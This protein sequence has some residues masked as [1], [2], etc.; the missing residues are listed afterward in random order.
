MLQPICREPC[1]ATRQAPASERGRDDIAW[2]THLPHPWREQVVAPLEFEVFRE[3]EMAA[4]RVM[5]YDEDGQPCYC[6][7]SVL[8]PELRSDDDEEYYEIVTYAEQVSSWR[9]R[10]GRWLTYRLAGG[11]DCTL[12]LNGFY[13][14]GTQMPR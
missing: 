10:D 6:A 1:N 3:Y 4:E 13:S 5:G 9:L 7:H 2:L 14:F 11:V 12:P 8:I